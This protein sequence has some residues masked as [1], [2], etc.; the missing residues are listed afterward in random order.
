MVVE[1]SISG[2]GFEVGDM[3]WAKMKSQPWWPGHVYSEDFATPLVR[4]S[5]R[6]GEGMLLVAFFGSSSFGW[7][8]CSELVSFDCNYAEM[9]RQTSSRAF[10]RAVEEAVVEVNRRIGLGMS[11]VCRNKQ[12][13]RA[14]DVQGFVV[15]DVAGYDSGAVYSV[16]AIRKARDGFQPKLAYDFLRQLALE[17]TDSEHADDIN[18]V[19]NKATVVAYRKAVFKDFDEHYDQASIQEPGRQ[20]TSSKGMYILYMLFTCVFLSPL[21]N[22]SFFLHPTAF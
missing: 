2:H 19:K 22:S 8:D 1:Q 17:P 3:V 21:H 10:V 12:S 4:R 9:C 15:V 6:E 20:E 13:F 11:C 18:F 5:K 14:I 16:D 7:F